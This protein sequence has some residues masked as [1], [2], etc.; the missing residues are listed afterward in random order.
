VD[1]LEQHRGYQRRVGLATVGEVADR[2]GVSTS[3][4]YANKE[5][6]GAIRLGRGPKARLRFDLERAIGAVTSAPQAEPRRP[7]RPPRRPS[8]PPGVELIEARRYPA[9][10]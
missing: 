10:S 9:G 4:V 6:L 1:L 7:A 5:K 3:W 8:L 2:L